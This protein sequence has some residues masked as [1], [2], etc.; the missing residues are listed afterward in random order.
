M[1]KTANLFLILI[2]SGFAFFVT[3]AA[4]QPVGDATGNNS[5]PPSTLDFQKIIPK[6]FAK[7]WR[8]KLD[9]WIVWGADM[10]KTEDGVC[11]L[12][13]SY[14]PKKTGFNAWATHSRIGY[15]TADAPEGPYTY[16]RSILPIGSGNAWDMVSHNPSIIEYKGKFYLYYTGTHGAGDWK[17]DESLKES[18]EWWKYRLN[19]RVGVAVA[20]YPSGPWKR[21]D[22]PLLDV[23]EYGDTIAATPCAMV[24]PEDNIYLYYKTQLPG[25][26]KFGRGV[27]H[28]VATSDN[29]LGPFKKHDQPI[30][31]KRDCFPN[32]HFN[33]HIDDHVEWFQKDRYY[34]IV[35]DHDAPYLTTHGQILHLMESQDGLKW[36]RSNHSFVKD[37]I[38]RWS[39]GTANNYRRLE[40]PKIFLEDGKPRVLFLAALESEDSSGQSYNIAVPLTSI[41]DDQNDFINVGGNNS[42]SCDADNKDIANAASTVGEAPKQDFS[43]PEDIGERKNLQA[44][45][46]DKLTHLTQQLEGC[47]NKVKSEHSADIKQDDD[48]NSAE[49]LFEVLTLPA[50][51]RNDFYARQL[52]AYVLTD[53]NYYY[54]GM[55][56]IQDD[57]GL[58]HGYASRWPIATG[59]KGW[60]SHSEIAH[61]VSESPS[62]P[63]RYCDTVISNRSPDRRDAINAHNPWV[64]WHRD[65]IFLYYV[66][67]W[68]KVPIEPALL[69]VKPGQDWAL[70]QKYWELFRNSQCI[71][72]A[73]ANC[74][75][76]AFIRHPVPVIA[77]HGLIKNITVNPAVVFQDGQL[78]M[79]L[80]GDDAR[81]EGVFRIQVAATADSAEGPFELSKKPVF[82]DVQTEDAGLWY[83]SSAGRYYMTCHVMGER[84]LALFESDDWNTWR[85]SLQPVLMQK[86]FQLD[87]GTIWRPERV[88][89]PMVLTDNSGDPLMLYVA[90]FDRGISGNIA[91]PLH[92]TWAK[93]ERDD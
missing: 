87:D 44:A 34:A 75:D 7:A 80:K 88:E 74:P 90:V 12:V 70:P 17:P 29:P 36:I 47:R 43:L 89:R 67:N 84:S 52:G 91:V 46:P 37:K 81:R 8:F 62:G 26:G 35:K 3:T 2:I 79:I 93:S 63:F 23:E 66:S 85:R 13:F 25:K 22:K 19:M 33:F 54:W 76:G 16:Q 28:Y 40:M 48:Y 9:N 20:D 41:N 92:R 71:W 27:M 14:W 56:V 60:L 64:L 42:T 73:V 11:H 51:I 68:I 6:E 58:Y 30:I 59:F 45:W 21:F 15:A 4:G 50:E 82:A 78:R 65:K 72:V 86:E 83:D 53:P 1:K 49:S 55:S 18:A 31:D 5:L 24:S 61:L 77:P 32:E 39:D 57:E 38:I 69:D 10:V